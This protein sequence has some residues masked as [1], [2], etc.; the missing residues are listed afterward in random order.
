M[1]TIETKIWFALRSRV[2]TLPFSPALPLAYPASAYSPG[3]DAFV[4]VDHVP[5]APQRVLV[6]K[7]EHERTGVLTLTHV[8]PLGQE[9]QYYTGAAGKIAAHFPED[10]QMKYGGVCVR[11]VAKPHVMDGY[12]DGAWF[13]TPVNIRWR[14]AA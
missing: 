7:G 1:T 4:A 10:L 11:V 2:S 5:F 8:A 3:K 9:L 12:R 14:T 6:G 13:R